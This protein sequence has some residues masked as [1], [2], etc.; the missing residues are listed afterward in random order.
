[1]RSCSASSRDHRV[2]ADFQ[3]RSSP[4]RRT[5]VRPAVRNLQRR[6]SGRCYPCR[7]D[8][9][10]AAPAPSSPALG[11]AVQ[12]VLRRQIDCRLPDHGRA[13]LCFET[14]GVC[15]PR[16][17]VAYRSALIVGGFWI[18]AVEFYAARKA[19]IPGVELVTALTVG[20]AQIVAGV[21]PGTSRS[22]AS[23]F[24]A[25]LT[26]TTDRRAH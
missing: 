16:D 9:L 18:I 26:G 24:A 20:L 1:M 21:F 8:H 12:Q 15:A 4:H 17:F 23:I 3:H 25:M 6:N 7:D 13:R 11:G 19:E 2:P 22:G 14:V 5:L 10:L